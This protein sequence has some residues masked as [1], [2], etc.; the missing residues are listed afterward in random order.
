MLNDLMRSSLPLTKIV[1]FRNGIRTSNFAGLELASLFVFVPVTERHC[2]V[3]ALG[4]VLALDEEVCELVLNQSAAVLWVDRDATGGATTAARVDLV[5]LDA[6]LAEVVVVYA[7]NHWRGQELDTDGT[8][9]KV[10][11][12]LGRTGTLLA[13]SSG[14]EI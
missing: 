14:R 9:E 7:L 5:A 12:V 13:G 4:L 1:D 8:D 11:E 6:G 2:F 10:V 3:A